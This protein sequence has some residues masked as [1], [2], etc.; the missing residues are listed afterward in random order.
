MTKSIQRRIIPAAVLFVAVMAMP[1]GAIAGSHKAAAKHER[2]EIIA[3]QQELN[4]QC[5]ALN[6][7]GVLGQK[8]RATL[9]SYQRSHGLK[10]SGW[11]DA[12]TEKALK[13]S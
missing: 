6:V 13:V 4:R 2:T 11:L 8:T 1:L 10:P 7:D 12:A 9:R 3:A 5:A